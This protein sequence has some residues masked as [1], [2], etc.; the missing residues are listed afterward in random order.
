[1][2]GKIEK[3]AMGVFY[4]KITNIPRLGMREGTQCNEFISKLEIS[5]EIESFFE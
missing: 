3:Y 1:M 5:K 2:P 4:T